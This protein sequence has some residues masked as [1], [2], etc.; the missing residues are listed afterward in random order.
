MTG[1]IQNP[2]GAIRAIRVGDIINNKRIV[3][4]IPGVVYDK[5]RKF[6]VRCLNCGAEEIISYKTLIPNYKKLGRPAKYCRKCRRHEGKSFI[7]RQAGDFEIVGEDGKKLSV[8]CHKCGIVHDAIRGCWK[9]RNKA[10][11]TCVKARQVLPRGLAIRILREKGFTLEAI[12]ELLE[13]TRE[14]VRQ[15]ETDYKD[16]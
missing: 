10:C 14:R 9:P 4:V 5:D 3:E 13:I 2:R 15:I 11:P 6:K 1:T 8:L 16:N 12:G 7:G